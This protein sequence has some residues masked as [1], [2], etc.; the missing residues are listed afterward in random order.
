MLRPFDKQ[1]L[2][3]LVEKKILQAK[4]LGGIEN[5]MK[6]KPGINLDSI[7]KRKKLIEEE[8]LAKIKSDVLGKEYATLLDRDIPGDILNLIPIDISENY[9]MIAFDKEVNNISIGMVNP[10]NNQALEALDF[11]SV[12]NKWVIKI[13]IVTL[14]DFKQT[15]QRYRSLGS[16]V[17]TALE[18]T[19]VVQAK[20][21]ESID[22]EGGLIKD[23]PISKIVSVI[24][25][26]G[27]EAGASD[28]HVEPGEENVKV[29]YRVDGL[30]QTSL[31]LPAYLASAVVSRVKVLANLKLDETRVPQDGRIRVKVS[32][33]KIDLRVS[34]LPL[35][36]RE[37]VTLRI[38]DKSTTVPSFDDLGFVGRINKL[39]RHASNQPYGMILVTGPTGSGKSTTLY[40]ALNFINNESINIVT[41]E[42]PIEYEMDGINQSQV[43]PNLGYTFATGLR[44]ILRQDPD[45]I[46][47]GEI[48]DIETAEMGIHAGLTGHL[49]F[50]TL[51][52]ND[53]FGA[54]PRLID[55]KV[56]PFL[57]ASTL[58][59]VLAQRLVRRTCEHC[60]IEIT[61][62]KELEDK[63]KR[64]LARANVLPEDLPKSIDLK[65]KLT[66]YKGQGCSRC[67]GTGY[68]GRYA[69]VEG[70]EMTDNLKKVILAGSDVDLVHEELFD[71][72]KMLQMQQDG[73]IKALRGFT[74]V[75][76]VLRVTEE[77]RE[78]EEPTASLQEKFAKH[79][80]DEER[81]VKAEKDT[82]KL[83][84]AA[85]EEIEI[86]EPKEQKVSE[87]QNA[88]SAEQGVQEK[89]I[90]NKEE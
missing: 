22:A 36:D 12:K 25:Q 63:V 72:Q 28:I 46:M 61:L 89:T 48:R 1:I 58:N 77:D 38:L 20:S 80:L 9:Q 29:R 39:I 11:L 32:N 66:F 35:L 70:L 55:M 85:V 81:K 45:V 69:I 14:T 62:E 50:S 27:V 76:E 17:A 67:R 65:G 18:R 60:K 30:L 26:H 34:T 13:Y 37:K 82:E 87:E 56:E 24:I 83:L 3:I 90:E 47:V 8:D 88:Q 51:H 59:L 10:L 21:E 52:T 68:K 78:E 42:D 7:L 23:A 84:G 2:D 57:M 19:D 79:K 54:I 49:L 31:L 5:E 75:E 73:F 86:E 40:A 64:E 4:Q 6:N 15:L 33:R 74:T 16:E 71:N 43:R 41:L 53:A 44:T